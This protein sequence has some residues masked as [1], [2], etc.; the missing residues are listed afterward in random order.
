[1]CSHFID[2]PLIYK[3]LPTICY[4]NLIYNLN[5]TVYNLPTWDSSLS[6]VT[7]GSC[8]LGLVLPYVWVVLVVLH[9]TFW[10]TRYKMETLPL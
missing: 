3:K 8:I 6:G 2:T 1:M 10:P 4:R 7:A 5:D 9:K